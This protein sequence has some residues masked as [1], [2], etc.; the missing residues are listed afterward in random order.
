MNIPKQ[1]FDK[2]ILEKSSDISVIPCD[3]A[4]S[5]IGS[6]KSLLEI[7]AVNNN[8]EA[9]GSDMAAFMLK[10]PDF[11]AHLYDREVA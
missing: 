11:H 10:N 4:W 5:D 9:V 2:A 8:G 6:W 7:G 3:P 1:P